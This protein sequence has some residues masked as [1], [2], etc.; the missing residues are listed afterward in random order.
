M[1]VAPGKKLHEMKNARAIENTVG[2]TRGNVSILVPRNA[3]RSLS[4]PSNCEL[5][6]VNAN[7]RKK[8][9]R[10]SSHFHETQI[11]AHRASNKYEI[12]IVVKTKRC[13]GLLCHSRPH[14]KSVCLSSECRVSSN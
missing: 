12:M 2:G 6:T 5:F 4:S 8:S 10:T 11:R 7:Y 13:A 1:A 14:T 9:T 3:R